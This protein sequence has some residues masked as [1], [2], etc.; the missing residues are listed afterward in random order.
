M[1]N[2][3]YAG[4]ELELFSNAV[5]W[6]NY[7]SKELK[8]YLGL[9]ILEV[10]AG[11]GATA[12]IFRNIQCE[13]WVALEPDESLAAQARFAAAAGEYQK[14]LKIQVGTTKDLDSHQL[15]DT[16]LYIDVLEHIAD[17]K[18]ELTRAAKHLLPEGRIIV[19]SPAH[20]WLFTPFDR[21]VGHV[22]RYNRASL[23]SAKPD[24]LSVERIFYLDSV[25]MM[26]SLGN[27][28]ILRSSMP[29][30]SQIKIWD[31]WMIPASVVMDKL[32]CNTIGKSIVGVF[33]LPI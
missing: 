21:A 11:I 33:R 29:S 18:E 8:S 14:N 27:R 16:I 19:L 10:G 17:H 31:D 12:R 7:W 26:A 6:K 15:F 24:H 1:N 25:G 30:L 9:N 32:F 20:Q 22:R 23:L 4:S 2:F 13:R 3:K 5:N 28:L